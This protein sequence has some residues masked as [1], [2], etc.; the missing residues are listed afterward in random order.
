ML[1]IVGHFGV[2]E[3]FTAETV[4]RDDVRMIGDHEDGVAENRDAA[5]NGGAGVADHA[6]RQRPGVMPDLPP[7]ARIE[8]VGLVRHGHVHHAV[9]HHRRYF[10]VIG[11]GD[12]E[13]PL[14][15]QLCD[16]CGVDLAQLAMAISAEAAMISRPI[17]WFRIGDCGDRRIAVR[18][19]R[20]L[21][22]PKTPS[23]P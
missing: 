9:H 7:A 14:S 10:Q 4:E 5:I 21:A 2:P 18:A 22:Q 19:P 17:A 13:H 23:C 12:G 20:S 6:F 3:E 11:I 8:R 15:P 1:A 16:I